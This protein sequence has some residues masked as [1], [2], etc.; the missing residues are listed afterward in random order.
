MSD[1]DRVRVTTVV[2][3]DPAAA[4]EIFTEEVD[5]WWRRG[6]RYRFLASG[7]LRFEPGVGGRLVEESL[8]G[9]GRLWEVGRIR[10]WEPGARLV[11]EWRGHHFEADQRTEVEV[12]FEAEGEGT[13]VSVEHRGWDAL[14]ADHRARHGLEGGAFTAMMGLWWGD[15]LVSLRARAGSSR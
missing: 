10:I 2:A 5:A 3:V 12:R 13:R 14:P 7:A 1:T 15:V 4:F 9:D 8:A 11:F 6:P